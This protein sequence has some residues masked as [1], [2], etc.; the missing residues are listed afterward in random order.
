MLQ[1]PVRF[2]TTLFSVSTTHA[3]HLISA[4]GLSQCL[5]TKI[6]VPQCTPHICRGESSTPPGFGELEVHLAFTRGE[7]I[8]HIFNARNPVQGRSQFLSSL[9]QNL[10]LGMRQ[11]EGNVRSGTRSLTT[12]MCGNG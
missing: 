5:R 1:C 6:S 8:H 7:S 4:S 2:Q 9:T 12:G 11:L 3:E 10:R